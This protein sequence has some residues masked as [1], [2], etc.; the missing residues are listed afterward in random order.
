MQDLILSP[1][2]APDLADRGEERK[3]SILL[4]ACGGGHLNELLKLRELWAGHDPV[5]ITE[6]SPL[7]RKLAREMP[8]RFVPHFAFGQRQQKSLPAMASA[9]VGNLRANARAMA[10][11]RP[12][13]V[14]TTGAGSVFPAAVIAR[15]RGARIA[16]VESLARLTEPSLFGRMV[17]PF[18]DCIVTHSEPVAKALGATHWIDPLSAGRPRPPKTMTAVLTVGTVMPFNRLVDGVARLQRDGQL[19]ERL[20]AQVGEGGR[21]P[22]GVEGGA[23]VPSDALQARL[24]AADLLFTHGGVGCILDGLRAGCRVVAMPR[25]PARGEHYDNHQ[26]DIVS[27][28]EARGLIAVAREADDLPRALE[29]ARRLDVRCIDVDW[30]PIVRHLDRWITATL[31][32]TAREGLSS[33]AG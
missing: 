1:S 25:D 28:L 23:F 27:A 22:D 13:L 17:S 11:L 26:A 18:A 7:G 24:M 4:L 8:V 12:D 33:A 3:A 21:I 20:F 15:V 19:P 16:F 6:D 10:G 29:K 30:A 31:A 5:L 2:V 14:I 32:G 9:F